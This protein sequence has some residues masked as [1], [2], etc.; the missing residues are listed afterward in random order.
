MEPRLRLRRNLPHILQH[1]PG[2]LGVALFRQQLEAVE[3]QFLVLEQRNRRPPALPTVRLRGG[4]TYPITVTVTDGWGRTA[5]VTRTV[6]VT[7]WRS[8]LLPT[9]VVVNSAS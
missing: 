3:Q 8:V 7:G 6:T 5:T 4:G 9:P 2:E 1:A